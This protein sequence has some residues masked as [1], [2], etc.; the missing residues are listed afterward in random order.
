MDSHLLDDR[1][2]RAR[3]VVGYKGDRW[4]SRVV[5]SRSY[6]KACG[7]DVAGACGGITDGDVTGCGPGA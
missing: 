2:G 1:V 4:L 7:V 3:G 5:C 6:Q